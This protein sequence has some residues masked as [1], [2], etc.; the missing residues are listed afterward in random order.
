MPEIWPWEATEVGAHVVGTGR[1]DFPNQVNNSLGFPAIFRGALDVRARTITDEMCMAAAVEIAAVAAGRGLR[2]DYVVPTMDDEAV[3]V[4][5]AVAVAMKAQEQGVARLARSR[6][7]L[8]R[9]ADATIRE[10]K[11]ATRVLMEAGLIREMP[12]EDA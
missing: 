6:E 12:G 8:T 11:T 1:S 7:E 3:Y 5:E 9:I 4:R 10:A 2:E